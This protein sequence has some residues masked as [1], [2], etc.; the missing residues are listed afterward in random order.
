MA[1][2]E[3]SRGTRFQFHT[4]GKERTKSDFCQSHPAGRRRVGCG[5]LVGPEGRQPCQAP[6]A[7]VCLH[8]LVPSIDLQGGSLLPSDPTSLWLARIGPHFQEAHQEQV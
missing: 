5:D 3:G 2:V 7:S 8:T 6:G 1:G 4:Q